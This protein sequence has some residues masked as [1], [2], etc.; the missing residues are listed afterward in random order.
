MTTTVT[1]IFGRYLTQERELR[2]LSREEVAKSTKIA[3]PVLE[4]M[5]SGDPKRMPAKAYMMG[6]LRAYASAVGLDADDLVLR[7]QEVSGSGAEGSP[8]GRRRRHPW[9]MMVVVLVGVVAATV[10]SAWVAGYRDDPVTT[11]V[12]KTA[13]RAPYS[14]QDPAAPVP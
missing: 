9:L 8:G 6:Y 5:E 4:A 7:W 14:Q 12:R 10:L 11:K 13:E 1:E 3:P 2:G